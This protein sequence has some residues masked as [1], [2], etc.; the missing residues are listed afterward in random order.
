MRFKIYNSP[1]RG[2]FFTEQE[3]E[4]LAYKFMTNCEFFPL[5]TRMIA[6]NKLHHMPRASSKIFYKKRCIVTGHARSLVQNFQISRHVMRQR[7]LN[8][9]LPFVTRACW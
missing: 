1:K 2:Q 6:A 5:R 7:A 8:E 4:R 9:K 3:V